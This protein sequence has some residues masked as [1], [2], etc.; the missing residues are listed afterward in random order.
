M[1]SSSWS[2]QPCSARMDPWR[3]ASPWD[4]AADLAWQT[5]TAGEAFPDGFSTGHGQLSQRYL[6]TSATA[7]IASCRCQVFSFRMLS[8]L[9]PLAITS[10]WK[11]LRAWPH[12]D[13]MPL[14]ATLMVSRRPEKCRLEHHIVAKNGLLVAVKLIEGCCD[15]R[16]QR[17]SE[18]AP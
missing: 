15:I 6:D 12:Q 9:W 3:S 7:D 14:R 11:Y 13:Q 8:T 10:R 1:N 17:I 4:S 2:T 5:L 16:W 18:A